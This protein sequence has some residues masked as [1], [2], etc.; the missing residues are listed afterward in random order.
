MLLKIKNSCMGAA[1][2]AVAAG[3][4]GSTF[5][6]AGSEP[7]VPL[8]GVHPRLVFTTEDLPELRTR[9]K[10]LRYAPLMTLLSNST[11]ALRRQ[12]DKAQTDPAAQ[13]AQ[14]KDALSQWGYHLRDTRL[15]ALHYQLSGDAASGETAA[16]GFRLWLDANPEPIVAKESWG[17]LDYALTYDW[18]HDRLNEGE[19]DKARRLFAAMLG[20]PTR[21]MMDRSWFGHGV[22]STGRRI[23]GA[24]WMALFGSD[25][26]MTALA[27][28]GE[29]ETDASILPDALGLVRSFLTECIDGDGALYEGMN[30][31]MG[32][33]TH[34]LPHVL[35]AMRRRG[36]D[37][38]ADTH[39]RQ[40]ADWLTYETL[41]W[42][43]ESF[44]HNK[45]SGPFAAG[46]LLTFAAR[47]FGGRS[48][49]A[50]RNGV[51][52]TFGILPDATIGL[53]NGLP[54]GEAPSPAELPLDRWFSARGLVF[55]RSGWGA[56]DAM[57]M[58]GLNPVGAGHTHADQGNFLLAANGAYFIADSGQNFYDSHF[59]N[60]VHIDGK[61]QASRE[62]RLDG[63]L[64]FAEG[65]AYGMLADAD[66]KL[67][68]SRV[69]AGPLDGGPFWWEEYNPV[70]RADR[71]FLFVRGATGPLLIVTDDIRKDA[72]IREYAWLAHTPE[73]MAVQVS[74]DGF[75]LGERYG[76][77]FL[78]TL[79]KGRRATL[80]G[81]DV[82]AGD[83]QG[84]LLVRSEPSPNAW[85]SNNLSVNGRRVPYNDA[86]FGRGFH[87]E[88]WEWLPLKPDGDIRV[89]HPGGDLR[90]GLESHSGGQIA[91]AVFSRDQAWV[92]G[93][94]VPTLSG[95]LVVI[96][97]DT[98]EQ[99][100]TPWDV[101]SA[102]K[103]VLDARF[104]G[105][106]AT[107]SLDR[108]H[109]A[110]TRRVGLRAERR[111]TDGRFVC[112]MAPH[113]E[114]DGRTLI[115][116][117]GRLVRRDRAGNTDVVLS[118]WE[119]QGADSTWRTDAQ[120]AVL[121]RDAAGTLTGYAMVAGSTV[122]DGTGVVIAASPGT[123][124]LNDGRH[125]IVRTALGGRVS[126]PRLSATNLTVNGSSAP[127]PA[128]D[129][130]EIVVPNPAPGWRIEIIDDGRVVTMNGSGPAPAPIS[131]PLAI[132]LRVNGIKR[133]FTR[134][135][136]GLIY[137]VLEGGVLTIRYRNRLTAAQLAP[138]EQSRDAAGIHYA[139]PVAPGRYQVRTGDRDEEQVAS[140]GFLSL[141]LSLMTGPDYVELFPLT[142]PLPAEVWW[143]IGPF[144][145]P[146]VDGQDM[147]NAAVRTGL[148]HR[149]PP[150]DDVALTA[151]LESGGRERR[152]RPGD[153]QDGW[154]GD[155]GTVTPVV[156]WSFADRAPESGVNFMSAC[157]VRRGEVCYAATVIE[158]P[159]AREALL[160]IGCDFWATAFLNG[161]EVR[162]ERDS[163]LVR[164][165]GAQFHGDTRLGARIRLRKGANLLLVKCRG[166]GGSNSFV[167]RISDPGDLIIQA[168][169][170]LT[171]VSCAVPK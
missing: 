34:H 73:R 28:E 105:E 96:G 35:L 64:R 59:H 108:R 131:A 89:A 98:V 155:D 32:F 70:E 50:Y 104:L 41:P 117:D 44:D 19:R 118:G 158:S 63:F 31:A 137:P 74:E 21:D 165:D 101:G 149:F 124:V 148:T 169:P 60:L 66:L 48:L 92:P 161:E 142:R 120:T 119:P 171:G 4:G 133:Q 82:P 68:Y 150:E 54:E 77:P 93:D 94:S 100:D 14:R 140:A 6:M 129:P 5:A 17:F 13:A 16:D 97:S 111:G 15:S 67:S 81:R 8:P 62:S 78:H 157:G 87:R 91:L 55:A 103:G 33:G 127:L 75:T 53:L 138:Y 99:G 114:G 160:E 122:K 143:A 76:G 95:D 144:A 130:I 57:A 115:R 52:E 134:D 42:G 141:T 11:A 166:G 56:R 112:V 43:Y 106:P 102:P 139:I 49:W 30:Y 132:E 25:L 162:S 90:V 84:W 40:M 170:Q 110:R 46:P 23:S 37:L 121:S 69:V 152:W 79:A 145:T 12:L 135:A 20:R 156:Q 61:A 58:F 123:H 24:N 116:E 71:R 80:V 163:D 10:E 65:N 72:E 2:L 29:A 146:G 159:D 109:T 107:L 85:A 164:R 51:L 36:V 7:K 88:G 9:A 167:A 3:W 153:S 83:Y 113:D 126:C 18:I 27:I 26:A 86:Y 147:S 38:V 22:T 154:R 128:G 136:D 1:C 168:P 47:E 39:L 151:V 125:L 45:S